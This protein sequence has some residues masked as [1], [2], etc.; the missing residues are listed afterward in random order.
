MDI[1]L[2][3]TKGWRNDRGR[4]FIGTDYLYDINNYNFDSIIGCSRINFPNVVYNISG[5]AGIDGIYEF[6]YIGSLGTLVKENIVVVDGKVIKNFLGTSVIMYE[7]LTAGHKCTFAVLNDK[8]FIANGYDDVLVYDGTN[9]YEMGAPLAKNLGAAG[10]LTGAYY[11][12]ITYEKDS[13]ELVTGAVS[14][15]VNPTTNS[16]TVTC[17]IGPAGITDRKLYRTEAGRTQLKLLTTL[18]DNTTTTFVDNIA[19]SSLGSD[20]PSVNS[21]APKPKFITVINE[22][23]VGVGVSRRPNYLY[24]SETEIESLFATIGATDVS[25]QGND[26]T[27]LTGMAEDYNLIVVFSEKRIYTVDLSGE[28]A[29]VRQ[30]TSN[31][32]CL[33]GHSVA[34]VPPNL[35]FKGG[36]MFVSNEYDVRVFNGNLAVN[37]ATSFDNLATENFS[38]QLNPSDMRLNMENEELEGRFFDYKYHLIIDKE[39]YIYDIRIMG[40]SK[41]FIKTASYAP[42]YRKFGILGDKFYIGQK[43]TGIVEEMYKTE[44]YRDEP[45][46]AF[47][48]TAELLVSDDYKYWKDLV[49]YYG[50]TGNVQQNVVITPDN[51]SNL[52]K[53]LTFSFN[54]DGFDS[55][56]F[57]TTYFQ[58]ATNTDDYKVGH[59]NEYAKWIRFRF[60]CNSK[61]NFRGF[62]MTVDTVSNQE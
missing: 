37:L 42:E 44:L 6:R 41:Y 53:T 31:V 30:T 24:Y 7:G 4:K 36:L 13:V 2:S 39:I 32:G 20:I 22:R 59:I 18:G 45:V 60:E 50:N 38:A 9:A 57:S 16:I 21:E 19:D 11:Y 52:S 61:F 47:F 51:N 23:L 40:W 15:T 27:G 58:T 3:Q 55:N 1:V 12:A 48:E 5:T 62:R 49:I 35:E 29:S 17:P 26:N 34:K 33:D 46:N 10:V 25:G 56:Y 54:S 43:N 28:T 14:N 8:L